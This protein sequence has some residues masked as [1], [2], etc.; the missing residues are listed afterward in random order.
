MSLFIIPF[1]CFHP[2]SYPAVG[3]RSLSLADLGPVTNCTLDWS[4]ATRR[5][6]QHFVIQTSNVY[7][8][9]VC[10]MSDPTKEC[11][12]SATSSIV[13]VLC[14]RQK[15]RVAYLEVAKVRQAH[16]SLLPFSCP[17]CP[18]AASQ[19]DVIWPREW[20]IVLPAPR[21]PRE[22][23]PRAAATPVPAQRLQ[24]RAVNYIPPTHKHRRAPLS[25]CAV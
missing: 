5:D 14:F 24:R 1:L 18:S 8:A 11:R 22:Q 10:L 6:Q 3:S 12:F 15:R 23:M 19:L 7:A 4:P 20:H 25:V 16:L 9:F 13:D 21:R 17:S 2:F